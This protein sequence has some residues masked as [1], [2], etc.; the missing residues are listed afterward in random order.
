[1]LN[2]DNVKVINVKKLRKLL[3]KVPDDHVIFASKVG[4]LGIY[5]AEG[6]FVGFVDLLVEDLTISKKVY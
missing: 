1:M 5:N 4:N 3:K 6:S 2:S